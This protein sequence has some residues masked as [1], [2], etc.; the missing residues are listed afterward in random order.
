M[1][2]YAHS[3]EGRPTSEWHKLH[4]HLLSVA[5]LAKKFA[6]EFNSGDW[7]YLAGLWHDLGKHSADFQARLLVLS[8]SDV[9]RHL[10]IKLPE[11]RNFRIKEVGRKNERAI[12]DFDGS[13]RKNSN[14][15]KT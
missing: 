13:I 14:V 3:L 5:S 1:E 12:F 4:D 6:R 9:H 2:F 7:A 15:D 11:P 10:I 8:S